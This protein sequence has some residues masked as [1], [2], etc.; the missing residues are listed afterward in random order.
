M[1]LAGQGLQHPL[2]LCRIGRLAVDPAAQDDGRVD[3]EDG[4]LARVPRH[5]PGLFPR[6]PANEL[7]G[8]P[9]LHVLFVVARR[10]DVERDAELLEDR[11]AL[12]GSRREQ[13]RRRGRSVSHVCARPRSLPPAIGDPSQE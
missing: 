1:R 8:V 6:V 10:H 4:P 7:D 2:S 12:R 5:R 11:T 9:L 13:E 3:R